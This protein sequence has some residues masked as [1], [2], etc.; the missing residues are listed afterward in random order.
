MGS[1]GERIASNGESLRKASDTKNSPDVTG[2]PQG[3]QNREEFEEGLIVRIVCP[4]FNRD[5]ICCAINISALDFNRPKDRTP[6]LHY[7]YS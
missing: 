7:Y 4:S 2:E 3:V 6:Y 1:E 5:P